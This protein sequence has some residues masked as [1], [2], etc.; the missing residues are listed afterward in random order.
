MTEVKQ[1]NTKDLCDCEKKN[2][3]AKPTISGDDVESNNYFE[4]QLHNH[5]YIKLVFFLMFNFF[6]FQKLIKFPFKENMQM[7]RRPEGE[8]EE[9]D[10]LLVVMIQ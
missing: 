5:I 8:E 4:D 7:N 9:D 3:K 6:F 1:T 2:T 10:M